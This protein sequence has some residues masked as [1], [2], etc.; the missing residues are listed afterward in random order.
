M[1]DRLTTEDSATQSASP[2]S[3]RVLLILT[4]TCT[5]LG[6]E[7]V[8]ESIRQGAVLVVGS[9]RVPMMIPGGLLLALGGFNVLRWRSLADRVR[10]D[11][12]D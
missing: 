10:A 2:L 7:F 6:L 5:F 4:L 12:E 9:T 1:S 11:R 8:I 3:L